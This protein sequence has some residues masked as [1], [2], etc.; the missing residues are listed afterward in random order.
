VNELLTLLKK[1]EKLRKDAEKATKKLIKE[2]LIQNKKAEVEALKAK[3]SNDRMNAKTAIIHLRA[4]QRTQNML[5]EPNISKGHKAALNANVID[6]IEKAEIL[7]NFEIKN[8][9]KAITKIQAIANGY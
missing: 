8:V 5:S 4:A 9:D 3:K 7:V 6:R 1:E 2:T